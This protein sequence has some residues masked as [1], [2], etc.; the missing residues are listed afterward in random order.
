[1]GR[2]PRGRDACLGPGGIAPLLQDE[3]RRPSGSFAASACLAPAPR[4]LYPVFPDAHA[5]ASS[6][7]LRGG[8][9]RPRGGCGGRGARGGDDAPLPQLGDRG[10]PGRVCPRGPAWG[11]GSVGS[12]AAPRGFCRSW[13]PPLSCTAWAQ[14]L[15][16]WAWLSWLPNRPA[17]QGPGC[18]GEAPWHRPLPSLPAGKQQQPEASH[19]TAS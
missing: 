3:V 2:E 16:S 8:G 11:K 13:V 7:R 18:R 12:T 1:M 9:V 6:C 5:S 10:P 4:C 14:S 19:A 17:G 15:I